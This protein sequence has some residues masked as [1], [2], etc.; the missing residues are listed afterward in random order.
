MVLTGVTAGPREIEYKGV[1]PCGKEHALVNYLTLR[2]GGG[3]NGTQ[4]ETRPVFIGT[5]IPACHRFDAVNRITDQ[6]VVK[7]W[8]GWL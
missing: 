2:L 5:C 6:A 4:T 1:R 7:P 3:T 8:L